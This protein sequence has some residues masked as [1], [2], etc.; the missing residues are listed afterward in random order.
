MGTADALPSN[1]FKRKK[2]SGDWIHNLI[3]GGMIDE[4]AVRARYFATSAAVQCASRCIVTAPPA[5]SSFSTWF[6]LKKL[7]R[8]AA[9]LALLNAVKMEITKLAPE[10]DDEAQHHQTLLAV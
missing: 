4:N 8:A 3:T 5:L 2:T 6:N 9:L 7:P 1:A 10:I